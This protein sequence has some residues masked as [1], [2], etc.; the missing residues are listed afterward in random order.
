MQF[1]GICSLF[2]PCRCLGQRRSQELNSSGGSSLNS[3][4]EKES[5]GGKAP[6]CPLAKKRKRVPL[7]ITQPVPW[8]GSGVD[9]SVCRSFL[10]RTLGGAR[11][12]LTAGVPSD[13]RWRMCRNAPQWIPSCC[14]L[15]IHSRRWEFARLNLPLC[16]CPLFSAPRWGRSPPP[17]SKRRRT[18]QGRSSSWS[19]TGRSSVPRTRRA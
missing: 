12:S 13:K 18:S 1:H 9:H 15:A 2:E 7:S 8:E 3:S 11:A 6:G 14:D 19:P 10:L 17:R 5:T 16:P 4:L